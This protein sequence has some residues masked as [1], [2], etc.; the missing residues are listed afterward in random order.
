MRRKR[1]EEKR[2][3][4]FSSLYL[5]YCNSPLVVTDGCFLRSFLLVTHA[6]AFPLK[7][8]AF[9]VY[10]GPK[11]PKGAW[12]S[13]QG[14]GAR[15]EART[16]S[17]RM[18]RPPFFSPKILLPPESSPHTPHVR[19]FSGGLLHSLSARLLY[20]WPQW[21]APIA[22]SAQK[23]VRVGASAK[24]EE[25][26]RPGSA[27]FSFFFSLQPRKKKALRATKKGPKARDGSPVEGLLWIPRFLFGFC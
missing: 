25:R 23:N 22:S 10:F 8:M 19:P 16:R 6:T 18:L 11:T 1:E 17:P 14:R 9:S 13:F 4:F 5:T 20:S 2:K 7:T 12:A 27:V 24:L 21:V 26:E 15:S 3:V